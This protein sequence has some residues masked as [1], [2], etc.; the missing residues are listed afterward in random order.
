MHFLSSKSAYQKDSDGSCDTDDWSNYAEIQL[1]ITRINYILKY[2]T[3]GNSD[4]IIK[5]LLFFYCIVQLMQLWYA[6]ETLKSF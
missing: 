1:C 3:L 2:V 4:L 5:I 6:E